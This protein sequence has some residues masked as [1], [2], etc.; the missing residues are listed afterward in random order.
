MSN[1]CTIANKRGA[2]VANCISPLSINFIKENCPTIAI[3]KSRV[4]EHSAFYSVKKRCEERGFVANNGR[5]TLVSPIDKNTSRQPQ[6]SYSTNMA[7]TGNILNTSKVKD[8][9]PFSSLNHVSVNSI[10]NKF[11][12]NKQ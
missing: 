5:C 12:G 2:V 6:P 4:E 1:Q 3:L 11:G 9:K 7:R 10:A 8:V